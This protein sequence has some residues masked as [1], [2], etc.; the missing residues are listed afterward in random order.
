MHSFIKRN[1]KT[2]MVIFSVGLTIAFALPSA[3]T[4]LTKN[5]DVVM[6][7]MG[8]TKISQKDVEEYRAQWTLLKQTLFIKQTDPSTR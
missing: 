8:K 2:I 3:V 1:Q 4:S 6:G 7:R 5:R